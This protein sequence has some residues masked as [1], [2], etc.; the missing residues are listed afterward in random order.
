VPT[1]R[2]RSRGGTNEGVLAGAANLAANR[3][4]N[5]LQTINPAFV[6]G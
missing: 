4:V 2:P 3:T 1:A 6:G 5:D